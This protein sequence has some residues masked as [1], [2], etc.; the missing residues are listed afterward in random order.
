MTEEYDKLARDLQDA[1]L[2]G[3]SEPFR[4]E[5]LNPSNIGQLEHPDSYVSITGP[6]GDTIKMSLAVKDEKISNI[7]FMT[8]GCG[9][10]ITCASYVTRAV[11]GKTVEETLEITPEDVIEY[12]E[13]LPDEHKHC[14]KLAVMTLM[15]AIEKYQNQASK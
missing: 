13:G 6:C 14:T 9:A 5:F 4:N 2:Q 8:D 12:F 3:Y 11:K 1:I 7:G 10:T 15:A